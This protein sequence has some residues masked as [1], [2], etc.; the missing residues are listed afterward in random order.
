MSTITN[1]HPIIATEV[2]LTTPIAALCP[3]SGEPQM[4]SVVTVAYRPA[5]VLLELHAVAQWCAEP[6]TE[7]MDLE[8][9][10]QRLAQ[11]AAAA[12]GVAVI[13]TADYRLAGGLRMRVEVR[14]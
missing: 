4:G 13:V 6:A 2:S 11:R 10:A 9:F 14:Q 8:T 12:L 3:H 7:A 1:Q 5:A